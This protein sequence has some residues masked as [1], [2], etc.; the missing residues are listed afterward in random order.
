[1][2]AATSSCLGVKIPVAVTDFVESWDLLPLRTVSLLLENQSA[3]SNKFL[4]ELGKRQKTRIPSKHGPKTMVK[5]KKW[6]EKRILSYL[7]LASADSSRYALKSYHKLLKS[8]LQLQSSTFCSQ[9]HHFGDLPHGWSH[10]PHQTQVANM[11]TTS[12]KY[13][14]YDSLSKTQKGNT[15]YILINQHGNWNG[16]YCSFSISSKPCAFSTSYFMRT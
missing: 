3:Q 6:H 1:M 12:W 11:F 8:F 13:A 15:A 14:A 5:N 7:Y 2:E 16:N 10:G 9:G 4:M